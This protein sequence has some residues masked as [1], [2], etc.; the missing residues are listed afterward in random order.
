MNNSL[1]QKRKED[2]ADNVQRFP[3]F[4]LRLHCCRYWLL[5]EWECTDMSFPFWRLYYNTFGRAT[6]CFENQSHVLTADT[7]TLIPPHTSFSTRLKSNG[8]G[9]MVESIVGKPVG[10]KKEWNI[11]RKELKTDHL[12][13]HFN[14]GSELDGIAPGLYVFNVD[15]FMVGLLEE[16]KR[17]VMGSELQ[18]HVLSVLSVYALIFYCLKQ[19]PENAWH[20]KQMDRRVSCSMEYIV[21]HLNRH[22]TNQELAERVRMANNSFARLFHGNTGYSLQ[23]YI[24]K[25]RVEK[26]CDLMH[27][28]SDSM[29]QIAE[30]C[31]FFDRQ[32]FSKVFRQVM[33]ISPAVYKKRH[34]L[35]P[36]NQ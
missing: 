5:D 17:Q 11:G 28:S 26:A 34:T 22:I 31:G 20:K 24:R 33:D 3:A 10:S 6:V 14:L 19:I 16:I 4:Q 1:L 21:A 18:V 12:F 36:G 29:E 23:E 8:S 25:K 32:H 7:V 15:A 13:V 9:D 2:P 30:K 35:D 27:H